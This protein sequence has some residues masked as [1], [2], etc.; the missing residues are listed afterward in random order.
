MASL[1]SKIVIENRVR[2]CFMGKHK[3]LFH[4]WADNW[5]DGKRQTVA[6]VEWEDGMVHVAYPN[7][8]RF[9]D[10][11]VNTIHDLL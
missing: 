1:N 9:A 8:I 2:P 6:I 4:R 11:W 3:C 10:D 5:S 7:E